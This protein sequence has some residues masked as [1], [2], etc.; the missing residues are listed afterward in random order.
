MNRRELLGTAILPFLHNAK[1]D[2]EI[3]QAPTIP[4]IT[5]KLVSECQY[6]R[7]YNVYF[8]GSQ[9]MSELTIEDQQIPAQIRYYKQDGVMS[10]AANKLHY[11]YRFIGIAEDN[12]EAIIAVLKQDFINEQ[13][14]KVIRDIQVK[15]EKTLKSGKSIKLSFN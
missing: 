6:S 7:L 11:W 3:Y 8:D 14:R 5:I 2:E 15:A 9:V 12:E 4:E 13:V 1:A 10:I